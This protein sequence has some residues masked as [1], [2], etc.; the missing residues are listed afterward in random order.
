M[1]R[2]DDPTVVGTPLNKATFLPDAV[3]SAIATLTGE[4]INLPSDALDAICTA[5]D[6][7]GL[8]NNAKISAFS[9]TGDG[10]Y[11]TRTTTFTIHPRIVFYIK[12]G[13]YIGTGRY[14][15]VQSSENTS[16]VGWQ[17]WLYNS[18]AGYYTTFSYS[19]ANKQ[20]SRS[21]SAGSG[22]YTNASKATAL[23]NTSG[24]TY[25]CIGIGVK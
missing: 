3:A 21:F 14:V 5:L 1:T 13:S 22:T 18:T 10:G 15:Y 25:Y 16:V 19:E 11:G 4:T 23:M 24:A 8:T 20:L 2:A 17:I 7:M 12:S 9:Y 6:T